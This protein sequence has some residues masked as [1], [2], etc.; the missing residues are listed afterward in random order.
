MYN[1]RESTEIVC[2]DFARNQTMNLTACAAQMFGHVRC[3]HAMRAQITHT[4][5]SHTLHLHTAR[6]PHSTFSHSAHA[7]RSDA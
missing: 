2:Q 5:G 6:M 3:R 4:P 1:M 7:L